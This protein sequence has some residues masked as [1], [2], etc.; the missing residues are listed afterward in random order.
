MWERQAGVLSL[1]EWWCQDDSGDVTAKLTSGLSTTSRR[2]A[3]VET[4]GGRKKGASYDALT[5]V[6]DEA[7]GGVIKKLRLERDRQEVNP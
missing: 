1:Y 5:T 3:V 4:T 7:A 2:P 6:D